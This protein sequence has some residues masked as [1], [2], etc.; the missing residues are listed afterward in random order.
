MFYRDRSN[1]NNPYGNTSNMQGQQWEK[2][3]Q[4]HE[5]RRKS[6]E[7]Q[8][9]LAQEEER[10]AKERQEK[11]ENEKRRKEEL[12]R[13]KQSQKQISKETQ[14]R[15][16]SDFDEKIRGFLTVV[17]FFAGVI[18]GNNYFG[19]IEEN[20]IQIGL[21][22]VILAGIVHALYQ[23]IKVLFIIALVLIVL[24]FIFGESL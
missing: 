15:N 1:D 24:Y 10:R 12:E 14:T 7:E 19:N 3:R 8:Q 5:Q 18:L 13:N 20:W 4:E 17:A 22:A 21:T 6:W 23:L 2:E 9:Y 11:R 16:P